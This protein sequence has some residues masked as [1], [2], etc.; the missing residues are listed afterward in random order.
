M[1]NPESFIEE[2]TEEVRRD[3]LFRLMRKY[4]WIAVLAVILLVGGA[5]WK[6][7][8]AAREQAAAR[9][10]GDALLSALAIEDPAG[11][12]EALARLSQEGG[13]A[14]SGARH[15]LAEILRA[16]QMQEAGDRKAAREALQAI[17]G[18]SALPA[19]YRDL[20]Q[21][22]MVLIAGDE[23]TP[24]QRI[25][26]LSPLSAPGAP[27][28]L[29]AEEQIALAE[30]AKGQKEAALSRLQALLQEDLLSASQRRRT[31][32]LIVALGGS[33]EAA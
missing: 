31:L 3:R 15:A 11:R 13:L 18:D 6:E 19:R 2:V 29:L 16:A 5:A 23:M 9:A 1:S 14:D 27:Y 22:R 7:W 21:L 17:A 25:E 8:N 20:A 10:F 28:R 32:Q 33:P 26:A 24:D 30:I 4:G 12:A